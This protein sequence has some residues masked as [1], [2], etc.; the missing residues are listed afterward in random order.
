MPGVEDIVD[1]PTL[2]LLL[3]IGDAANAPIKSRL[4][5][6]DRTTDS[7]NEVDGTSKATA[8]EGRS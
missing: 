7:V 2:R 4:N 1:D 5:A 3:S 8:P 6:F